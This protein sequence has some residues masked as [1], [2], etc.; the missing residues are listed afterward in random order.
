M[1]RSGNSN[2]FRCILG[3]ASGK[4]HPAV[5]MSGKEHPAVIISRDRY[6]KSRAFSALFTYGLLCR[7]QE[8]APPPT[9]SLKKGGGFPSDSCVRRPASHI[10]R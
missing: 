2:L 10:R 5:I 3:A 7:M 8:T 4:E 6:K 9:P 1:P